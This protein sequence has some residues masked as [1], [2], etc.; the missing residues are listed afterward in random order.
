[1]SEARYTRLEELKAEAA[2]ALNLPINAGNV[3][4]L[5]ALKLEHEVLLES[6]IAGRAVDPSALLNITE[7]IAKFAPATP[8]PKVEVTFVERLH[9]ICEK[10][11]HSQPQPAQDHLPPKPLPP[12]VVDAGGKLKPFAAPTSPANVVELR[13]R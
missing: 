6:L 5:S 7:A 13:P 11:G 10:C 1:M 9:G 8:P 3:V 2:A 4:L 12:P